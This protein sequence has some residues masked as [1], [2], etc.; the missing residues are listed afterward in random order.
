MRVGQPRNG[1]FQIRQ[2]EVVSAHESEAVPLRQGGDIG[3]AAD[4]PLS[5]IGTLEDFVNEEQD[6]RQGLFFGG[7]EDCFKPL[8]FG[9]EKRQTRIERIIDA[10]ATGQSAPR[11]L[12]QAR[13]D[14]TSGLC[15]AEVDPD[16]AEE[17]AFAGHVGAGDQVDRP[18]SR[19]MN[20]VGDT[21]PG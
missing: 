16:R 4:Q 11:P 14:R 10:D 15:E 1:W 20:I 19:Q 6:R 2:L 3:L 8:H 18:T 17:R 7:I 5:V 13:A 9:V 12:E 21:G